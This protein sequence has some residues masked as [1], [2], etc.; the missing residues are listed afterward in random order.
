MEHYIKSVNIYFTSA[1][2][3]GLPNMGLMRMVM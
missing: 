3:R 2:M 1:V